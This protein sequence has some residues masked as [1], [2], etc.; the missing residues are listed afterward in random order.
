MNLQIE[1]SGKNGNAL[2]ADYARALE[3]NGGWVALVRAYT[4][5]NHTA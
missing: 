1:G 5:R 2:K 4:E 3:D